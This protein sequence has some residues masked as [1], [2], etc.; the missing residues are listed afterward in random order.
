MNKECVYLSHMGKDAVYQLGDKVNLKTKTGMMEHFD[1]IDLRDKK[2]KPINPFAIWCKSAYRRKCER[3]TFYPSFDYKG[4]DFNTFTGFT[5]QKDQAVED[6]AA[7]QP[8]LDHIKTIW[9]KD[10]ELYY[11]YVLNWMAHLI[12]KPY[13]KIKV[14]LALKSTFEGAGKGCVVDK[15]IQIIGDNHA[16]QVA[17]DND[18]FGDKTATL[19]G[20]VLL[21]LDEAVWGGNK[22]AK[23]IL[24]NMITEKTVRIRKMHTDAYKEPS[25]HALIFCSNNDWFLP[26]NSNSRRYFAL[27]LD[28]RWV[29]KETPESKA[30]FDPI[31]AIKTENLAHFLYNRDISKFDPRQVPITDLLKEQAAFSLSSVE[32]WFRSC[33]EEGVFVD[34]GEYQD[35]KVYKWNDW[36]PRDVL[37]RMYK[38]EMAGGYGVRD[39]SNFGKEIRK[40]CDFE[41]RRLHGVR[42]Q[43][44]KATLKDTM[45]EWNANRGDNVETKKIKCFKQ[46]K[47]ELIPVD[48]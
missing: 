7:L 3:L 37:Y 34:A 19:S 31:W 11:E 30:Y 9:C 35:A 22:K 25:F 2:D 32:T 8:L 41:E 47:G 6:K 16:C 36:I 26:A 1:D 44:F 33:M 43:K 39:K 14:A 38:T 29:G 20:K 12:Q 17:D 45:A 21:D 28:N 46:N 13:E 40:L 4:P 48:D 10:N 24:K 27:E 23:G 5:I 15:L 42:G 18:L